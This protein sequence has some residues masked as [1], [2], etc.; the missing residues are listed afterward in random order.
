MTATK[1]EFRVDLSCCMTLSEVLNQKQRLI[2]K[3]YA[4][5]S[6]HEFLEKQKKDM[7]RIANVFRSWLSELR[8]VDRNSQ[9]VSYLWC[10]KDVCRMVL[11]TLADREGV[12]HG[13]IKRVYAADVPCIKVLCDHLENLR[14]VVTKIDQDE[15]TYKPGFV[16]D[17]YHTLGLLI[18]ISET[19]IDA[20]F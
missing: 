11:T 1:K 18:G 16:E 5:D 20:Y 9:Q 12:F 19:L 3:Q 4:L 14:K 2:D 13:A 7:E 15:V 6:L 8:K 17:I 10:I